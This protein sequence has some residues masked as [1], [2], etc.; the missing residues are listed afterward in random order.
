MKEIE[1]VTGKIKHKPEDFIVEEIGPDWK[2]KVSEKFSS[3]NPDLSK[4]GSAESD[5]LWCEL[6]KYDLD[7]FTALKDVARFMGKGMDSIG[8]A[9]TKDKQAQTSQRISIFKPNLERLANFSH[10]NIVL[11]NFKWAK[12]KIKIGYLEGNHFKI[13]IRDVDKKEAAKITKPI[14]NM[15]WFPNYFGSQRFG[16]LRK[17]NVKI[18]KLIIKRKFEEAVWTILTD[19]SGD[20]RPEV[21]QARENLRKTRDITDAAQN[22]PRHLRQELGILDYLVRHPE[23][24]LGAI[25]KAERKSM[26]MYIN[27]VQSHI[28]NEIL[29]RALD[30][31]MDFTKKGQQNCI[32]AGYKTKFY[33]GRLGEIEREVMEENGLE[34][35]DFD[36]VEIPYLRIKGSFRKAIT[37]VSDLNVEVEDDE[38][39]LNS[40]KIVLSFSLPSGVYA[41]TYLENF[42]VLS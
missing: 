30:E 36:V 39:F 38:E 3:A 34:L 25:K 6:E 13:V 32:L 19:T 31:G 11:K 17:N 40:K 16:S 37:E 7:H 4:L 20:E 26:L 41:T 21:K 18:G 35:S 33:E 9:G 5:F 10:Q 15:P 1:L 23:D 28:F 29:R 42:F 24:Y 12:R 27:S 8:Y 2:C 22:F 14:R